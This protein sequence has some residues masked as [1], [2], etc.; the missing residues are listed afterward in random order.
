MFTMC[1]FRFKHTVVIEFLIFIACSKNI[2][3]DRKTT[4]LKMF[5]YRKFEINNAEANKEHM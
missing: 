1:D 2:D 4:H 3:L 5:S